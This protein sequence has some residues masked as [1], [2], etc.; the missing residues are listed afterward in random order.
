MARTIPGFI[1]IV[2]AHDA[3]K[4]SADRGT[5]VNFSIVI[6]KGSGFFTVK[7]ENFSFTDP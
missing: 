3:L 2:P 6:A 5:E 1:R 7:T 4:M